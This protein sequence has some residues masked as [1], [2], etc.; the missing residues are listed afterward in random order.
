[1]IGGEIIKLYWPIKIKPPYRDSIDE[2]G[3]QLIS[4]MIGVGYRLVL[5]WNEM[6]AGTRQVT[7]EDSHRGDGERFWDY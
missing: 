4:K 5:R 3:P 2:M 1:V 7:G 6:E